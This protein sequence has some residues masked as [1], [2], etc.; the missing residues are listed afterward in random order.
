MK[1]IYLIILILIIGITT[2]VKAS[3]PPYIWTI[4][5]GNSNL[6][7]DVTKIT[8]TAFLEK[9]E[10]PES[11]EFKIYVLKLNN[12]HGSGIE[13]ECRGTG[14]S[15]MHFIIE[16]TGKNVINDNNIGINYD[17]SPDFEFTGNGS[18]IINAPIPISNKEYKN[19]FTIGNVTPEEI[20]KSVNDVNSKEESSIVENVTEETEQNTV[21][22]KEEDEENLNA[23]QRE[24]RDSEKKDKIIIYTCLG[25][26]VVLILFIVLHI[27]KQ[28]KIKKKKE[29]KED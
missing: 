26:F 15:G 12:Y 13:L 9:K 6:R 17:Y 20:E 28:N 23:E 29:L 7:E 19:L 18:L 8:D 27:L 14:Q 2:N 3:T 1:K 16:L 24:A 11:G 5:N 4:D 25:A 21:K 10:D 22:D